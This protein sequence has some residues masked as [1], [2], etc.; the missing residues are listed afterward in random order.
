MRANVQPFALDVRGVSK[1]YGSRDAL[2]GVDLT[3]ESGQLHGLLGPNGAG[4]TTLLRVMLGLITHDAGTVQIFGRDLNDRIARVPDGVAG[5]VEAPAFYP[6]LSGR[7]N[8]ELLSCLDDETAFGRSRVLDARLEQVGLQ[9]HA[10]EPV[11]VYSAGMRQRLGLASALL[12]SPRLLFLD[13]PTSSLDP[14]GARDVRAVVRRLAGDGTAIVFSSHDMAEVEDLC[15][16]LTV[17]ERGQ[18]IFS[19]TIDQLRKRA[20]TDVHLLRTSNDRAALELASRRRG[21]RIDTNHD[22]G[23][24]ISAL[25]SEALDGYVIALG[26]AGIAVRLL[27]RRTRSLESLFLELTDRPAG[28][29][30]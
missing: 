26:C 29:E 21:I 15:A 10:S 6:Y 24:H 19:G 9:A 20:P 13:E 8:L 17:I 16:T 3:V 14:A 18:V 30:S 22:A 11:A 5:F 2:R 28:P 27:E 23:I 4:K 12:R 25:D 1:Q 7:Q